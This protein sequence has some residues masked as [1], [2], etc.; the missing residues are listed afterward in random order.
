MVELDLG[1]K[2]LARILYHIDRSLTKTEEFKY[3]ERYERLVSLL[4]QSGVSVDDV[5]NEVHEEDMDEQDEELR[6]RVKFIQEEIHK[7]EIEEDN[8]DEEE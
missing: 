1:S 7:I 6:W 8:D 5:Y 2:H 3:K 4:N